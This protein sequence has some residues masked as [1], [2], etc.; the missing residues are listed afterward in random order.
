[1]SFDRAQ[2]SYF[3]H[4]INRAIPTRVGV[5]PLALDSALG[6]PDGGSV[7][8]DGLIAAF[9][10]LSDPAKQWLGVCGLNAF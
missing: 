6:E 2:Q 5:N 3:V 9:N 1:M 7:H 10:P 8:L 4:E